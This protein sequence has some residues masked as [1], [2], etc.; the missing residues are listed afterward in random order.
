[1]RN[2][3]TYAPQR[4]SRFGVD[5]TRLLYFNLCQQVGE[6][7]HGMKSKVTLSG[8]KPEAL[9]SESS[10]QVVPSRPLR[11]C[12]ESDDCRAGYGL[13]AHLFEVGPTAKVCYQTERRTIPAELKS[14]LVRLRSRRS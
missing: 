11:H 8:G 6:S 10:P 7:C 1:M 5:L 14:G 12:D 4:F 2:P 3:G 13:S 9:D